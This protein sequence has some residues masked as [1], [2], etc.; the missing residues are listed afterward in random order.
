MVATHWFDIIGMESNQS[1]FHSMIIYKHPDHNNKSM[2]V[3][4]MSIPLESCVKLLGV[5]ID[6]ELTVSEHVNYIYKRTSRQLN[7]IQRISK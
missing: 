1:K 6:Y 2:H 5:F 4:G 3:K 7:A